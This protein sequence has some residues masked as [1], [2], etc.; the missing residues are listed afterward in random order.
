MLINLLMLFFYVQ[1]YLFGILIECNRQSSKGNCKVRKYSSTGS[2]ESIAQQEVCN[3][4]TIQFF[5]D[6]TVTSFVQQEKQL[7]TQDLIRIAEQ[8]SFYVAESGLTFCF[9]P[10]LPCPAKRVKQESSGVWTEIWLC[11]IFKEEI[12]HL[13]F[14]S[15]SWN[16]CRA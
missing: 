10:S 13:Y 9:I 16:R 6:L 12:F 4:A 1:Q 5:Q 15:P 14:I 8:L 11:S 7:Q 3:F 2:I